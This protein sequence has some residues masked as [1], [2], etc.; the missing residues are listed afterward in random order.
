VNLT[1]N[2]YSPVYE[3]VQLY[4]YFKKKKLHTAFVMTT[5]PSWVPDFRTGRSRTTG[6]LKQLLFTSRSTQNFTDV[7]LDVLN[8]TIL[9]TYTKT[10][11]W[12]YTNSSLLCPYA[13]LKQTKWL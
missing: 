13:G 2:L 10:G 5:R 8:G 4:I 6:N 9:R 3:Q 7:P 1:I 12:H 11:K